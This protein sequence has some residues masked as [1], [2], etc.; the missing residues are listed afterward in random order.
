VKE[1]TGT[2]NDINLVCGGIGAP[3]AILSLYHKWP[4]PLILQT[5]G[6][7]DKKMIYIG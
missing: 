7:F 2:V 6:P 5:Y 3:E 1:G 4:S